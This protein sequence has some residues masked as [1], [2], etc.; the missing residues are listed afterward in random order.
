MHAQLRTRT[1]KECKGARQLEGSEGARTPC[2]E[3]RPVRRG[4]RPGSGRALEELPMHE[5]SRLSW[6]RWRRLRTGASALVVGIR[7]V[8]RAATRTAAI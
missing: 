5:C 7:V 3:C 8:A 6:T 2:K 4:H 1:S